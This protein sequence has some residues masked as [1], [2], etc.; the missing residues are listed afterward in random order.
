MYRRAD[1]DSRCRVS[2]HNLVVDPVADTHRA[3][4]AVLP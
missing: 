4:N 3:A 1:A 2:C